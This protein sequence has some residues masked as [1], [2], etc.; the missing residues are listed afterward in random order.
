M[1]PPRIDSSTLIVG[2]SGVG[3]RQA[4]TADEDVR[5]RDVAA[6]A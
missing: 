6:V 2:P 5:L 3:G 1:D 4:F